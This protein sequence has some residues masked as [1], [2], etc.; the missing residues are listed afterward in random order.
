MAASFQTFLQGRDGRDEKGGHR[1][2][3]G[4][5]TAVRDPAAGSCGAVNSGCACRGGLEAELPAGAT[6]CGWDGHLS[7][8]VAGPVLTAH[9]VQTRPRSP[10]ANARDQF[11]CK[12]LT[13]ASVMQKRRLQLL[14]KLPRALNLV[15]KGK[16]KTKQSRSVTRDALSGVPGAQPAGGLA[17]SCTIALGQQVAQ[18]APGT[19]VTERARLSSLRAHVDV[20]AE[21]R[22]SGPQVSPRG[23]SSTAYVALWA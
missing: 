21:G 20:H 6:A 14:R 2:P 7:F 19:L 4:A 8:T 18:G 15:K 16:D 17:A 3:S 13:E 22:P 11:P 9:C 12:P 1:L 5:R 23:S 10:W